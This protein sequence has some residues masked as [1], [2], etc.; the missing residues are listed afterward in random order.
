MKEIICN[1][2]IHSTYSD[3]SENYHTIASAALK[4]KVDVIIITDHNVRV[5]GLEGYHKGNGR[6]VMVLTGE[7]VHD[8]TREPQKNHTLVI[9]AEKEMSGFAQ[10]P[11]VLIDEVKKAGGLSF[12][13]HPYEFAMPMINEPDISWVSWDVEGFTGLELWNGLSELKTV[14]HNLGD[15]LKYIYFPEMMAHAPLETTLAKWD[16]L[17][18]SG[19][20]INAVGGAD[21]H[22]IKFRKSI[23]KRTVFP[24][25]FHF[26]A[27]NNHLLIDEP[28][29]GQLDHD[30][31]LVYDALRK[32]RS[33]I[34]YD[35]PASTCGFRFIVEDGYG[36]HHLGE[37]VKLDTGATAR[38]NLPKK[39]TI[40][41]I[42]N[43]KVIEEKTDAD[44]LAYPL[45]EPGYYR[46]ECTIHYLGKQRGWIYSNPIFAKP[47]NR[48]KVL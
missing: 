27:I 42:H 28:F 40:R 25:E 8:Q 45:S 11:Q 4:T 47:A 15:G 7:E 33:F 19:K 31:A 48:R 38:I 36:E 5:D 23:L 10:N 2:H 44:R 46:V 17:L 43:G 21:A 24:Y 26:S 30:K 14:V 18:N 39:A 20:K 1:L 12:L 16:E 34:G 9:G 22:A 35:L 37:T 41:L 13:A 3:G 29:T 32:G 6:R